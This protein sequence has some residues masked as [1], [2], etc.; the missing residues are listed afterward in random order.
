M[1]GRRKK[2]E[3]I[4]MVENEPD[5]PV[6]IL[7]QTEADI[8]EV[9]LGMVIEEE[10]EPWA[11]EAILA[12]KN[13]AG[14]MAKRLMDVVKGMPSKWSAM[15][16][17]QQADLTATISA[18]CI[19]VARDAAMV[20]AAKG[21]R[22]VTGTIRSW[23][24]KDE[25]IA[26]IGI[27]KSPE[28]CAALGMAAGG[29]PVAIIL[30]VHEKLLQ[31]GD[32]LKAEVQTQRILNMDDDDQLYASDQPNSSDDTAILESLGLPDGN[33]VSGFVS[34]SE[35]IEI[36]KATGAT[37]TPAPDNASAADGETIILPL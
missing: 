36:L 29:G 28:V 11:P 9:G 20:M 2:V 15:T 3:E 5:Q 17:L 14:E 7:D 12:E 34:V 35:A 21:R 31:L 16:A 24:V 32:L 4:P 10:I 23:S 26:S 33:L 18:G 1:A 6:S 8:P 22:I 30:L 25:G 19:H 37:I 27:P 13:L